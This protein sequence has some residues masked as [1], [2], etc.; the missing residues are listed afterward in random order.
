MLRTQLIGEQ[1]FTRRHPLSGES[2]AEYDFD[3]RVA[4][5]TGAT[6]R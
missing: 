6:A 4:F 1:R 5:V 3:G 2:M